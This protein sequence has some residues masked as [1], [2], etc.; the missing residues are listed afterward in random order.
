MSLVIDGYSLEFALNQEK[1]SADPA[2]LL[3]F[4]SCCQAVVCCRVSPK[5]KADLVEVVRAK[6]GVITLAIGDGANDVGMIMKVHGK[7]ASL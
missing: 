4:A 1:E 3:Q 7:D 2:A 5:Q 6:R